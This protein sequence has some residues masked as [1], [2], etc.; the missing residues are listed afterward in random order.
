MP[1]AASLIWIYLLVLGAV[2]LAALAFD[3][4]RATHGYSGW[5][6]GLFGKRA[7]D[8]SGRNDEAVSLPPG[9]AEGQPV[10][11]A[12]LANAAARAGGGVMA[13]AKRGSFTSDR[14]FLPAALEILESP[15]SPM[16]TSLML[17]ICALVV[18]G[19]TWAT[20]GHLD[21]YA[22][23]QGKIQP[24]GRTKV[25]QPLEAGRVAAIRVDTGAIVQKDDILV[26]LDPT[27]TAADLEA[28][29]RELQGT[30]GEAARRRLAVALARSRDLQPSPVAFSASVGPSIRLREQGMLD[31]DIEQLRAAVEGLKAQLEER[32]ATKRRLSGSIEARSELLKL[33]KERVGMREEIQTRGAGSRALIIDAQLQYENYVTTDASERGQLIETD[34]AIGSL[35]KRIALTIAQFIAEQEQKALDMERRSDRLEQEIIKARSRRERTRLKAPIAGIIQQLDVHTLG[36]VV[37]SG[38]A[39]LSVVPTDAPLELVVMIANK[40]IGFVSVGQ[41][42]TVKVEAFPF[43][44][45]GTIEGVVV[46]VSTDAVEERNVT[47]LM[48]AAS[49]AR[50]QAGAAAKSQIGQN[51]VFPAT[52]KL[53]RRSIDV[54]GKSIPLTPGMAVTAEIK[55]GQRRAISYLL[56]PLTEI[57]SAS[58]GE[59]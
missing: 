10:V 46:Q 9:P 32:R 59:R 18:A 56:S 22:V 11:S 54:E 24:S 49:A 40:D 16:A 17:A 41:P 52:L 19:L 27:E 58:G 39:V 47:D 48:D 7:G 33:S 45:Y 3:I 53:K 26:E 31:A 5:L 35:D 50:P 1:Q 28:L 2:A 20:I 21:I 15:P 36:Q 44:R 12:P 38:Q 30:I 34:A 51:L 13:A 55:T 4:R 6:W 37:T 25:V 42:A 43:S 29:S 57:L 23:A 8:A 14:D